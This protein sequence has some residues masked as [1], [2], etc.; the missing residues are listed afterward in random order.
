LSGLVGD[1]LPDESQCIRAASRLI[2]AGMTEVVALTLGDQGA[3]LVTRDGAL[4]APPLP[5]KVVSTVGAGDSFLGAIVWSLARGDDMREAFRYGVAA[6]SAALLHPGTQLC[7]AADVHA[8]YG[9][10]VIEVV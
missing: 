8:L 7:Y 6:G 1:A 2:K 3:L 10:V 9:E 5:V 4:R